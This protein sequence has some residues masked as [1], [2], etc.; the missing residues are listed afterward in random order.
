MFGVQC[1]CEVE[2]SVKRSLRKTWTVHDNTPM[3]P[4]R[5]RR[6]TAPPEPGVNFSKRKK[7]WG[8]ERTWEGCQAT[9]SCGTFNQDY[10]NCRKPSMQP[11]SPFKFQ[12]DLKA[13]HLPGR[14]G[15]NY[16]T[17]IDESSYVQQVN[18]LLLS[19]NWFSNLPVKFSRPGQ[20]ATGLGA[21]YLGRWHAGYG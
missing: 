3:H 2:A 12:L 19:S 16:K 11:E 18:Y 6:Y 7:K 5:N 15:K 9:S 10:M 21:K 17:I 13:S 8:P 14:A 1:E 4:A 20:R